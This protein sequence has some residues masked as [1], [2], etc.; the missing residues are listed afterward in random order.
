MLRK[1]VLLSNHTEGLFARFA[2]KAAMSDVFVMRGGRLQQP[3]KSVGEALKLRRPVVILGF[4]CSVA[5]LGCGFIGLVVHIGMV[6]VVVGRQMGKKVHGCHWKCLKTLSR[7]LK[8]LKRL[9][10]FKAILKHLSIFNIIAYLV[11]PTF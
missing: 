2:M 9:S 1:V 3:Q 10:I 6:G 4:L 7:T 8:K 11:G 5:L